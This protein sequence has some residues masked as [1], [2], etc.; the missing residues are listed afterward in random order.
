MT[1]T[2]TE[3]AIHLSPA[4]PKAA[5][6]IAFLVLVKIP[7][8]NTVELA[9]NAPARV[10]VP[11]RVE[12]P[13]TVSVPPVLT[14]LLIVVAAQVTSATNKTAAKAPKTAGSMRRVSINVALDLLI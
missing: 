9:Y 3:I 13:E 2:T 7:S 6:N 5:P 10:V 14:L 4:A 11:V 12:A 8:L 1:A